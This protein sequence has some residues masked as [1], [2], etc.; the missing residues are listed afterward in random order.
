MRDMRD[1]QHRPKG[2]TGRACPMIFRWLLRCAPRKERLRFL[3]P[4][5][6]IDATDG[7][8]RAPVSALKLG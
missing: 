4:S 1:A 3:V 2:V 5:W 8:E 6:N 7:W